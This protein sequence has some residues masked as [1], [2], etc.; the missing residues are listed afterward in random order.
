MSNY[1]EGIF[2]CREMPVNVRKKVGDAGADALKSEETVLII[3][4]SRKLQ[5]LAHT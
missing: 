1:L 5:E 3:Y 2:F 4:I